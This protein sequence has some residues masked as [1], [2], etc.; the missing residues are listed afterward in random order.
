MGRITAE[1]GKRICRVQE[2]APPPSGWKE[3]KRNSHRKSSESLAIL[4]D[5]G[6]YVEL[7]EQVT[8]LLFHVHSRFILV[9]SWQLEKRMHTSYMA[10]RRKIMLKLL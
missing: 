5:F 8:I 7:P 4:K 9:N 6:V 10:S 3:H 2:D 1:T